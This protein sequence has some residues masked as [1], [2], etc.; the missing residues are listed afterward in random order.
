MLG[1]RCAKSKPFCV[2]I[3]PVVGQFEGGLTM[4]DIIGV[5]RHAMTQLIS[6][7]CLCEKEPK[8]VGVTDRM[9]SSVDMTLTFERDEPKIEIITS[10]SAVLTA[11][12]LDEPDLI[13]EVKEKAR[14]KEHIR[15]IAELFK[16]AYQD[17][18]V[19][20]IEDEILNPLAGI[21][22]FKEYHEKQKTI[23]DSLVFDLN[24]K[25]RKYDIGLTLLLIGM[26]EQ[27]GHIV[28]IANPGIW[29][30][31]DNL[32]FLCLG[33]GDRHAD[34]VFAWYKYQSAIPLNDAIYISFEAKKKAEAAGGVGQSTDMIIIDRDGI[35][36][37]EQETITKLEEIYLDREK[38]RERRG[39]D[40]QITKLEIRTKEVEAP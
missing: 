12:T 16:Q 20:H 25:I 2:Y 3:F 27:G 9:L 15:E 35:Q 36:M 13:R 4:G 29:R 30:S 38:T 1:T 6:A 34:N 7:M 17:L 14:G 39:F 11:G 10:K 5:G 22:T 8:V 18:R 24:E 31:Y 37:V 21:R 40:E 26:D 32:G 28:Q 23:H 33:M 19:A